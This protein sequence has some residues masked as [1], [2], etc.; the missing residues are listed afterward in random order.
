MLALLAVERFPADLS[1]GLKEG[2]LGLLR[3]ALSARGFEAA[4]RSP[5]FSAAM[6]RA[7][8]RVQARANARRQ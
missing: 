3:A 1:R 8:A 7:A 4:M 5:Q 2:D 6:A